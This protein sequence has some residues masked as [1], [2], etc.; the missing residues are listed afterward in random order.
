MEN[1]S[2]NKRTCVTDGTRRRGWRAF[3]TDA[4]GRTGR[5]QHRPT[6]NKTSG[7]KRTV[8]FFLDGLFLIDIEFTL[9]SFLTGC[10]TGKSGGRRRDRGPGFRRA[11]V[12]YD[13]LQKAQRMT[14]R[15]QSPQIR[16][17]RFLSVFLPSKCSVPPF[18]SYFHLL[19]SACLPLSDG[20]SEGVSCSVTS[21]SATPRRVC[22]VPGAL[23]VRILEWMAMPFSA[24][25]WRAFSRACL[26]MEPLLCLWALLRGPQ[27]LGGGPGPTH[28]GLQ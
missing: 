9:L 20:V 3:Q 21:D 12:L 16:S 4:R 10:Q 5:S 18:L 6:V 1:A 14:P 2:K 28:L 15:G 24:E 11:L 25:W 17:S 19:T 23:P 7:W 13:V 22:C 27:R 26:F 8:R